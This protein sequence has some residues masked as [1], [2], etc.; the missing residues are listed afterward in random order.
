VGLARTLRLEV[1]PQVR[2]EALPL[3]PQEYFVLSRVEGRAT[4]AE[5]I[6]ASGLGAVA[7]EQIL[8]RLLALGALRV[9][10]GPVAAPTSEGAPRKRHSTQELRAQ[11]QDR[12]RRVLQQQLVAGRRPTP[13]PGVEGSTVPAWTPD[14]ALDEDLPAP[15]GMIEPEPGLV[16]EPVP[17]DDPRIDPT[18]GLS[19]AEQR[20]L[21]ALED[22][23]DALDP[24]ELL[25]LRPTHDLKLIRDG[26]RDASRR[27][28]PD[29]HHG[30]ELGRFGSLLGTLFARAKAAHAALQKPEVRAPLVEAMEAR[31]AERLRRQQER[32]AAQQE[33]IAAQQ[34]AHKAAQEARER[35]EEQAAA[36]RR[37]A[38]TAQRADRER[39]RMTAAMQAKVAEYLQAA[40]DAQAT[41]NYA[42]AANNYRLAMQLDPD[43][44]E[45]RARW[46]TVRSIARRRRAKDAF[47]RACA[48]VDVGHVDQAIQSFL[49]AAE[50]DPTLEHL[51]RAADAVRER[52]P[53]RARDLAM[54]ALRLL[55]EEESGSTPP[56]PSVIA[57]LRLM[58]GR[59]FLAAGQ[60]QSASEQARLVQRLRP[61]DPQARALLNS[62]KV[63]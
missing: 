14:M 42:R 60:A 44:P 21:L 22:G 5:I 41:E 32:L 48:L 3:E 2:V 47:T 16:I 38:R 40:S 50:A 56:R 11:A 19:V 8:E 53:G 52:D 37:E 27:L 29:A 1:V 24:F 4:V 33:R 62:A 28:H 35:R 25:G 46:E 36:E 58:I 34:A 45:I 54:A 6:G 30:R 63:T 61:G 17:P 57:D 26:F 15:L 18:L 43:D 7:T 55:T 9:D 59:A 49:E 39:E 31:Q 13:A 23:L 20:S 10:E 51:A 12:R